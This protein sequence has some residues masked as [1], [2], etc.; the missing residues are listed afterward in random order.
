M[1]LL[2]VTTANYTYSVR[3]TERTGSWAGPQYRLQGKAQKRTHK[4][5]MKLNEF[6]FLLKRLKSAVYLHTS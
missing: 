5:R 3:V 4:C 2:L 6:N 1:L